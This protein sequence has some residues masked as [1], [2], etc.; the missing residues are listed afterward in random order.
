MAFYSLPLKAGDEI[1]TIEAEYASNYLAYMQAAKHKGVVI[2]IAPNDASGQV[3]VVAL[4]Q[5][6]TKNT[7]LI[8]IT[9]VP[10]QGG[11]INPAA[12]V[13]KVA[14]AHGILYLLDACQSVGQ[15]ETHLAD[16]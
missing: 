6:I 4:E 10:S 11:L 12:E 13:G 2:I 7:K 8:S 14:K 1:I 3:D 9:H 5:L 15:L 16:R